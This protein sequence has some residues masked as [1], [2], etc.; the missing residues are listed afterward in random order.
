MISHNIKWCL[1]NATR[2]FCGDIMMVYAVRDIKKGEEV[3]LSY[4]NPF[5]PYSK[6]EK[7][8]RGTYGFKC[9]CELC[10][11]ERN[12]PEREERAALVDAC[13]KYKELVRTNPKKV[14]AEVTP[15]IKKVPI[16]HYL[17]Y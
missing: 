8:F 16:M 3:T 13:I 5:Y 1:E 17:I 4:N 6:R 9:E 10:E 12:D 11:L 2:T 15:L 7:H 14:I